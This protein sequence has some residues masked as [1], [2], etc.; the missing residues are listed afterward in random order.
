[1]KDLRY[2]VTLHFLNVAIIVTKA[3]MV[4]FDPYNRK[5]LDACAT[6][7]Q[8]GWMS[9][10]WKKGKHA[11][12]YPVDSLFH[13]P[14]WNNPVMFAIIA[15][16]LVFSMCFGSFRYDLVVEGLPSTCKAVGLSPSLIQSDV[17]QFVPSQRWPILRLLPH[18]CL[19]L[20]T[21]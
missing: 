1:M 17:R 3:S 16:A 13:H 12:L 20:Y 14:L 8:C 2:L 5:D 6:Q 9:G 21:Y 7:S 19:A 4:R 18:L 10:S 15:N 11:G